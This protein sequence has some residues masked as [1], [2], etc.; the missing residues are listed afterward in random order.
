MSPIR[1]GIVLSPLNLTE[2][3]WIST[4]RVRSCVEI[5]I[6]SHSQHNRHWQRN[7]FLLKRVL[8]SITFRAKFHKPKCVWGLW[9]IK[10]CRI[11]PMITIQSVPSDMG[12]HLWVKRKRNIFCK[13]DHA[14]RMTEIRLAP[15]VKARKRSSRNASSRKGK[16]RV[17]LSISHKSM[18]NKWLSVERKIEVYKRISIWL[19]DFSSICC[20]CFFCSILRVWVFPL[21]PF[22]S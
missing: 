2:T 3:I 21:F 4:K 10:P 8:N 19:T 16:T 6:G 5:A 11:N 12:V 17:R 18:R 20:C 13:Y 7:G 14:I 22:T 15:E 1:F 9:K